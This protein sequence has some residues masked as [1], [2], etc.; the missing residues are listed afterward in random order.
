MQDFFRNVTRYPRYFITFVLGIFYSVFQWLRPV[1][2]NRL[3]AM[4]LVGIVVAIAVFITF[5][6]RAMLGFVDTGL[7]PLPLTDY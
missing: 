4:V 2:Q 1:M 5:T 3:S 7:T 6:M